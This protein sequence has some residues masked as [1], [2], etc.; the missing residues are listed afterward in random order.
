MIWKKTFIFEKPICFFDDLYILSQIGKC[1]IE[2]KEHVKK[3]TNGM[4]EPE[5]KDCFFIASEQLVFRLDRF[6]IANKMCINDM[7]S[8]Y[9]SI[10]ICFQLKETT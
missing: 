7:H 2:F 5:F 4:I 3:E 6:K 9:N 8:F 1:F 10:C